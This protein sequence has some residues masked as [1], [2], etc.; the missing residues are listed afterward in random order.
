MTPEV[1]GL[2]LF[3]RLLFARVRQWPW[4]EVTHGLI[5]LGFLQLGRDASAS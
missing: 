5:S 1:T 4:G 3:R 2:V